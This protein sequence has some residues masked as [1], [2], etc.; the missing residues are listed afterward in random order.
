[1]GGLKLA[2]MIWG[3][4]AALL[5][6]LQGAP[7]EVKT[8]VL[9]LDL[10]ARS[11][12]SLPVRLYHKLA[13]GADGAPGASRTVVLNRG[14]DQGDQ[15]A[16]EVRF[17]R[18]FHHTPMA[19]ATVDRDGGVVRTNP[20]FAHLFHGARVDGTQDGD[21]SIRAI[22]VERDRSALVAAIRAAAA[23]KAGIAPVDA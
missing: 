14:R 7:G 19:I 18:F 6:T 5:T 20:L 1:S 11:G 23:G 12:R 10:R 8:E 17:M 22:V 3:D 4:G 9:D 15:R 21:R 2:D 13:F 16:A